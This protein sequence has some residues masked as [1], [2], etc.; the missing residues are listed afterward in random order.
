VRRLDA[1]LEALFGGTSPPRG[2]VLP[3]QYRHHCEVI[4]WRMAVT[5]GAI[6]GCLY[7][8]KIT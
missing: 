1:V 8:L 3:T 2:L 4:G 6:D 5:F 7:D